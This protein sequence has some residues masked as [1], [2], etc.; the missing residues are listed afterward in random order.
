M[1]ERTKR[2]AMDR[3]RQLTPRN[4]GDS[5]EAVITRLNRWLTGWH[6]FFGIATTNDEVM[7]A[8]RLIDGNVRR[9][10]RAILLHHW[11]RKRSIAKRLIRL[12]VPSQSAWR[13]VYQGRRS[14]WA[15]SHCPAVD[16][17]LSRR[18]F[19]ARGMV[20]LVALHATAHQE[21]VAPTTPQLAL[22]A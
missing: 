15:L 11:K 7:Q 12:G 20:S 4:W 8:M 1:S 2:N 13:Q 16:H 3:I 18:Y 14:W 21:S 19:K 22:W 5:L 9:R 17:G 10:L 6:Q